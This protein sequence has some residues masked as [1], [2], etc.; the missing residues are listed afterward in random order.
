MTRLP[1]RRRLALRRMLRALVLVLLCNYVFGIG[2]LLPRQAV[3]Q[4]EQRQGVSGTR[5][6]A[7]MW[8]PAVYATHLFYLTENEKI[9]LLADTHWTLFGWDSGFG[10]ALDCTTGAPFYAGERSLSRQGRDETLWCYYGRVDDPEIAEI[11]VSIQAED[12]V[13]GQPVRREVAHLSAPESAWYES[14]G[15]RY[16]LLYMT[17]EVWNYKDS[18]RRATVIALD[19]EGGELSRFDINDGNYSSYG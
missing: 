2:L 18:F 12:Y 17:A 1:T 8:H 5:V 19:G 7:R 13:D 10:W 3:W 4:Q 9:T 11:A 14:D 15:R 16:F 6:A